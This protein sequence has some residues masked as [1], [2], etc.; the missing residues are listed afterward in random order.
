MPALF[1]KYLLLTWLLAVITACSQHLTPVTSCETVDNLKPICRFTNPEDIELLPDN[2]TLLVSQMGNMEGTKAGNLVSFD[3]MTQAITTQFP[4]TIPTAVDVGGNWGMKNCPGMPGSE[5]APHGISLK[6]RDDGRWQLAVINHGNRESVEMFEVLPANGEF[7]LAWRGCV[8]P[9]AGTYMNDVALLKNGGFV[10]SHMFDKREPKVLG[11]SL[12][13]WKTQ[14]HMNT[15]YALEWQ[16][17]QADHFRILDDSHGP[18]INGILVSA[19]DKTVYESVYA[20]NEIRKLDRASGKQLGSV[21]IQQVDNM[22]WD[23]SGKI[24]AASHTGRA[25]DQKDCLDHPGETCGFEFTIVHIDPDTLATRDILKHQG[26]PM[27]AATVA[28]QA[29]N[30]IYLGSFSG[31]RIVKTP[32]RP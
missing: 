3:T 10:A 18:F 9:P 4:V 8:V 5:F 7:T 21:H 14:L 26:A 31:D 28:K 16:P 20:G 23:L 29:G 30:N 27:G 19:D 11:M 13:I 32:Y 1:R 12:G 6:Q 17:A 25:L 2:R 24:L 22:A 15:G